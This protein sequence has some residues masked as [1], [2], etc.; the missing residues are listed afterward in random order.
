MIYV[1]DN[2][3]VFYPV[4]CTFYDNET[5]V[6]RYTTSPSELESMCKSNTTRFTE[7]KIS[8]VEPTTEQIARLEA[9]N[10]LELVNPE[11]WA[12][13]LSYFVQ[14]GY[15][16]S[17]CPTFMSKLKALYVQSSKEYLISAIKTQLS[18]AKSEAI[19][20]GCDFFGLTVKT[21]TDSQSSISS[22]LISMQA[23]L[24]SSVNFKIDGTWVEMNKDQFAVLAAIVTTH[25]Q[26]CFNTEKQ[27]LAKFQTMSYIELEKLG[28]PDLITTGVVENLF[29]TTYQTVYIEAIKELGTTLD[30]EVLESIRQIVPSA[31]TDMSKYVVPEFTSPDIDLAEITVETFEGLEDAIDSILD[32]VT[33]DSEASN[34]QD[35]SLTLEQSE[36]NS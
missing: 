14:Y 33:D 3:L 15:V 12:R 19:V 17:N 4:V 28:N 13:E 23:G 20:S 29:N 26:S 35:S 16:M 27:L 36:S 21:D 2:K 25:I 6:E 1:K 32:V 22:T 10:N 34:T 24:L 7:F 8:K 18:A 9:A 5:Y 30:S 11:A 31:S